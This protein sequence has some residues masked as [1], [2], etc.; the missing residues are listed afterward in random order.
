[1]VVDGQPAG[2]VTSSRY[3][4]AQLA[5]VGLAWVKTSQAQDGMFIDVRVNGQLV[6]AKVTM[7]P[8]YDPE[9]VRL[10]Q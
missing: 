7:K 3:S 10:R 6:K 4:P 8:F 1:V 2:R 5:A 9:G